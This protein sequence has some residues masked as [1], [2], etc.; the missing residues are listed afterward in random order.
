MRWQSVL[1]I[2]H[3]LI[4]VIWVIWVIWGTGAARE[5]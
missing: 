1:D 4:W 2:K 3:Q 5:S